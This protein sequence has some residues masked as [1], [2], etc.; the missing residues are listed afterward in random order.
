MPSFV[1]SLNLNDNYSRLFN[2][3]WKYQVVGA[4]PLEL[5]WLTLI[6]GGLVA[7]L[8][9]SASQTLRDVFLVSQ[10]S[11]SFRY[12]QLMMV[13]SRPLRSDFRAQRE[14]ELFSLR[15]LEIYHSR[16]PS[17]NIRKPNDWLPGLWK[18]EDRWSPAKNP[19]QFAKKQ[20]VYFGKTNQNWTAHSSRDLHIVFSPWPT[21][22]ITSVTCHQDQVSRHIV[23][24]PRAS[25]LQERLRWHRSRFSCFFFYLCGQLWVAEKKLCWF[26]DFGKTSKDPCPH[27]F[28]CHK[29]TLSPLSGFVYLVFTRSMT[30]KTH[31]RIN[32][33][34]CRVKH[35]VAAEI[36]LHTTL[37]TLFSEHNGRKR[38]GKPTTQ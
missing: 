6:P 23:I 22:S 19:Q 30:L 38:K 37:Q 14:C 8:H 12:A 1:Q 11:T 2:V 21:P 29:N 26:Q 10:S 33:H 28:Q 17:F 9:V 35:T 24:S 18:S 4:L 36:F 7:I 15:Q 34:S 31:D 27:H 16:W 3:A 5:T 32:L 25:Q 13:P 20:F